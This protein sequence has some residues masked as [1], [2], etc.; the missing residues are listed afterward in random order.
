MFICTARSRY[1]ATVT[2]VQEL[3]IRN[4]KLARSNA[5]F[6][7][8]ELAEKCGLSS[9]FIA[10]LESGRRFPSPDTIQKLCEVFGLRPYRFFFSEE[11]GIQSPDHEHA[12]A[13]KDRLKARLIEAIHDFH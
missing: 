8:A 9:F 3:F 6:T 10:E 2:E 13:F 11:D 4:L 7:Q 1:G 12:S 5:G